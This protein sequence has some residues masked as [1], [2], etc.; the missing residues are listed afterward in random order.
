[1]IN[2]LIFIKD[3]CYQFHFQSVLTYFVQI[4]N[5]LVFQTQHIVY[6]IL[7]G[8]VLF[9]FM[10]NNTSMFT[11]NLPILQLFVFCFSF[12]F[13]VHTI[14]AETYATHEYMRV[15]KVLNIVIFAV[16][17]RQIFKSDAIFLAKCVTLSMKRFFMLFF[18]LLINL[19]NK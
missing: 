5:F 2:V 7:F 12:P 13:C 3:N 11:C 8:S 19:P 4:D 14:Y 1:M 6:W 15:H 10:I 16:Q 9:L 17:F 18:L